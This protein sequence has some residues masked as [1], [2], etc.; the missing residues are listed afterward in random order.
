MYVPVHTDVTAPWQRNVVST[1][2][3]PNPL[4]CFPNTAFDVVVIAASLGGIAALSQLLAALPPDF[5]AAIM[6]V[7][8]LSPISSS[9]LNELLDK[10][11]A[12]AVQWAKH[13]DSLHPGVVYLAPP[14]HHVLLDRHGLISLS[15]SAPVQF[16]R[17]SAN[18]LFESVARHYCERTIAV[19]LTGMGLDGANGAQAIKRQGGRV[20]VQDR[21]TSRAYSMPQAALKT[22]SVDFVLPLHVI[23][24]ALI[25]LVMVR[26]A[27]SLFQ[28][29]KGPSTSSWQQEFCG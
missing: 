4:S 25:A 21:A 20:L 8:H 13:G 1:Q 5:P 10:R 3:K 14:D 2:Q 28:V 22:G 7:Q 23:A 19:V 26:G 17:P 11:T 27:A 12:L 16:A 9:R 29:T 15:Q 6:V 18:P 24:H